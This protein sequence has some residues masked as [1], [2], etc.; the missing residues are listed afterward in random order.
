MLHGGC[1][2]YCMLNQT[3]RVA[4]KQI[5][6]MH[7]GRNG[8]GPKAAEATLQRRLL[9]DV[10]HDE[11]GNLNPQRGLTTQT[12]CVWMT[13]GSA[14]LL[15]ARWPPQSV[16]QA[17]LHL[18][19]ARVRASAEAFVIQCLLCRHDCPGPWRRSRL[20]DSRTHG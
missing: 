17:V 15:Q 11:I 20:L 7:Y 1:R 18:G 10:V 6:W 2:M 19:Y 5:R 9:T 8:W 16:L 3:E 13:G 12:Y 14:R 4:S